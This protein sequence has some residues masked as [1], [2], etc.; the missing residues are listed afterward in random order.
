MANP[1]WEDDLENDATPDKAEGGTQQ[2]KG[3]RERFPGW[4]TYQGR[5][6]DPRFQA[7]VDPHVDSRYDTHLS[8]GAVVPRR[9]GPLVIVLLVTVGVV[10]FTLLIFLMF[11]HF[12][13]PSPRIPGQ[14][15][16]LLYAPP[17]ARP[18]DS[19]ADQVLALRKR[20][21]SHLVSADYVTAQRS[22]Q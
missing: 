6:N 20:H 3:W 18:A 19:L 2:P 15:N 11:Y 12:Q 5:P 1:R 14:S 13:R 4:E 17:V 16:S 21:H 9:P 10:L 8:A 7:T 22:R